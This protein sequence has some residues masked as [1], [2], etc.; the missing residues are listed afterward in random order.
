MGIK[1][2]VY[3]GTNWVDKTGKMVSFT[4]G[5]TSR[6]L[7]KID[8]TLVN[9]SVSVG[10]QVRA[11]RG[12]TV[13]FEGIIYNMSKRHEKYVETRAS[14]YSNLIL[15]DRYYAYR[16]YSTGMT[17]GAIIKDLA[18]LESG[19]NTANVDDGPSLTANWDIENQ[20][21]L[22]VFQ[23]I[24]KGTNYYIRMKPGK[25]LYYRPKTT[26]TPIYTIT[27]NNIISAEYS[28][29]R[30][31][32]KNR[33]IYLGANGQI[34]A[35]V[36]EGAGDLPI[37][38]SDPFLTD[39][40]EAQRRAQIRLAL[41]KEYGRQLRVV[42]HQND[43]ESSGIDLFSTVAVNLPSLGINENMYVVEISYDPKSLKY[44]LT[45]GGR[46]ELFEEYLSEAMGGDV[47]ARFGQKTSVAEVIGSVSLQIEEIS[48]RSNL[49][50]QPTL[51]LYYIKP[52]IPYQDAQNVFQDTDGMLKL[53][54]GA[55]SGTVKILI[56]PIG[57][58][59]L[60]WRQLIYSIDPGGGSY[61][62]DLLLGSK[63]IKNNAS[64]PYRFNY[65]VLRNSLAEGDASKWGATTGATIEDSGLSIITRYSLKCSYASSFQV[66]Y[67]SGKNWGK[68]LSEVSYF[69]FW[70]YSNIDATIYVRLATNDNNYYRA[71]T[72]AKA[73][74]WIK[75]IIPL[76]SFIATG[77]PSWSNINYIMFEFPNGTFY[78]DFDY[79]FAPILNEELTVKIT[80]SRPSAQ[81]TSPTVKNI[82]LEYGD[83]LT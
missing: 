46:L 34:L 60:F 33:V 47:A 32:L 9:D 40:T 51:F 57:S 67:P 22:K 38:I 27:Q 3:D 17:A 83:W 36:S 61:Q 63:T 4:H 70:I 26:S 20:I 52:P 42:M 5:L 64:S 58:S 82:R 71:N 1:L 2:E 49:L 56:K 24:A 30:W 69:M 10:Q 8:F 68:D 31:K 72:T 7:E 81:A 28:E 62:V 76:S 55:T 12:D 14:A 37:I 65:V 39:A 45:L 53:I 79:V 23:D 66:W 15:Y 43:F 11:K 75:N 77:S 74:K 54:S 50:T 13:F 16:S 19:V 29:D 48:K 21:V 44:T 80:L 59:D 6:E 25:Y 73:G 78:L 18:S 35:D 41:N